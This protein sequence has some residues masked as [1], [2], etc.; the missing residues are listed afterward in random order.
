M[1]FF[2]RSFSRRKAD[3]NEEIQAHLRMDIQDRTATA[4]S[5]LNKHAPLRCV[6]SAIFR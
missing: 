6:S 5:P 4:D 2:A 1:S 3:L